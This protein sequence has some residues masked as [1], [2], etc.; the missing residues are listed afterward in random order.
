MKWERLEVEKTTQVFLPGESHGQD[1]G[2]FE[3]MGLRIWTQLKRLRTRHA[4]DWPWWRIFDRLRISLP[5][6]HFI[7]KYLHISSWVQVFKPWCRSPDM[8]LASL[9]LVFYWRKLES[10]VAHNLF[11]CSDKCYDE[12][13]VMVCRVP[14]ERGVA[15]R[16]LRTE[17]LRMRETHLWNLQ[18]ECLRQR[19]DKV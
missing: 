6:N 19:E 3:S 11:S 7:L 4:Q 18:R 13:R 5:E 16:N 15:C 2:G 8:R 17:D 1:P 10:Q 9:E 12:N 14:E